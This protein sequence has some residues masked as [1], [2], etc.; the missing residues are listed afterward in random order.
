MVRLTFMRRFLLLLALTLATLGCNHTPTVA[1]RPRLTPD[2]HLHDVRFHSNI[3]HRDVT[4]RV[5]TPAAGAA[6]AK[7]P[8]LWLLHGAG[9]RNTDWTNNSDIASMAA[10]GMILVLPNGDDA[11]WVNSASKVK[12]HY[13]DYL[14]TEVLPNFQQHYPQAATDRDHNALLGISRGGFGAVVLGLHH[15]ETFGYIAS[16]SGALDLAER[17][18]RWHQFGM[19]TALRSTFGPKGSATR[20]ADDPFQLVQAQTAAK[21]YLYLAC[22]DADG[23]LATNERFAR[24]L[25][26]QG[27]PYRFH[28]GH[29]GHDWTLWNSELPR[30]EQAILQHFGLLPPT[31]AQS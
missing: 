30:I 31:M 15:P 9:V 4:Y 26:A 8:V 2:V 19:S 11:F 12:Q 10:Q 29:G 23:L 5:I 24:L 22:G 13:E 17:P 28:L 18:F 6:S 14:L 27:L 20:A 1:D 7:L 3:L 21:P 16:L 25:R